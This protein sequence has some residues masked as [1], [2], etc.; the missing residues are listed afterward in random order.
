MVEQRVR[1]LKLHLIK[2]RRYRLEPP[3]TTGGTIERPAH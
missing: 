2:K 1:L 3:I